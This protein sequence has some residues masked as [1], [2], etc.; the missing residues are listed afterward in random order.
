MVMKAN[1]DNKTLADDVLAGLL[2]THYPFEPNVND[3]EQFWHVVADEQLAQ[4]A[5]QAVQFYH[6]EA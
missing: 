2:A 5:G 1:P 3:D 6:D 4:L